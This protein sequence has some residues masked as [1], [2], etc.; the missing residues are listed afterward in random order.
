MIVE[1]LKNAEDTM[2]T[3]VSLANDTAAMER[4]KAQIGQLSLVTSKLEQL[5][6]ILDSIKEEGIATITFRSEMRD[7]LQNAVSSCGERTKDRKLDTD[8][9]NALRNAVESCRLFV[10]NTWKTEVMPPFLEL[11]NSLK[12]LKSLL[13]NEEEVNRAIVSIERFQDRLPQSDS[14][15]KSFKEDTIKA[16]QMVDN[17]HIIP[18]AEVFI[19]KVRMQTATVADLYDEIILKWIKDNHLEKQLKIRF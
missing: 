8:T 1:S 19:S 7:S 11:L 14:A 15:V 16:R 17:L 6:N 5:L 12:S 9:V 2:M 10:E 18:E 3:C 4:Y 13:Q